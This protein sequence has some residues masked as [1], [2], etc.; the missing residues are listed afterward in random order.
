MKNKIISTMNIK[1]SFV[2]K[3]ENNS[4]EHYNFLCQG[5]NL[6]FDLERYLE[7]S[8]IKTVAVR[9]KNEIIAVSCF[10]I[11]DIEILNLYTFV[12]PSHRRL[13]LNKAIKTFVEQFSIENEKL[14]IVSHVREHNFASLKSLE[15]AGY[16]VDKDFI[17]IYADGCKKLRM[18]KT[19]T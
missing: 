3:L 10:R 15:S 11:K 18:I 12:V 17:D 5:F 7:D 6:W 2:P 4:I 14:K 19:L 8:R 16:V 1:K 9:Y 13:G